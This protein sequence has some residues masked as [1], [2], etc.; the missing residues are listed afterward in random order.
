MK[1]VKLS[2]MAGI[3]CTYHPTEIERISVTSLGLL[4]LLFHNLLNRAGIETK[5]VCD[6][7]I[8]CQKQA[9]SAFSSLTV[10]ST[11]AKFTSSCI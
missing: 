10:L 1:L 9:L 11:Y 7:P 5:A 6:Y 8:L 2:C 3:T 4:D